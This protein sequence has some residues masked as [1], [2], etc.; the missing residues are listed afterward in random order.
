MLLS[1]VIE[2]EAGAIL[3]DQCFM[4]DSVTLR[5]GLIEYLLEAFV[6]AMFEA[7]LSVEGEVSIAG[8]ESSARGD[9]EDCVR[10]NPRS[11][12]VYPCAC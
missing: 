1:S 5:I 10:G 2:S 7:A 3:F 8:F 6:E 11:T 12:G 9:Q 4:I